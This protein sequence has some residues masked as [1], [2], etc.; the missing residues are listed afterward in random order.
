MKIIK[1][2]FFL[3]FSQYENIGLYFPVGVFLIALCAVMCISVFFITYYKKYTQALYK[4]LIR[5]NATDESSAKT[6]SQLRLSGCRGI[7]F[8]LSRSNGQLG[9]IVKR[10]GDVKPTYEEYVEKTK[11]RGYKP[12]KI[13]FDEAL[14][15]IAPD[16][17]DVAK[18]LIES[19]EPAWWK[20]IL[21]S[22]VLIGILIL[23]VFTLPDLLSLI[24]KSI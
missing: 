10:V 18:K 19:S 17:K 8:S 5:H 24:N 1:E 14:F 4:Q 21:I 9:Y 11:K 22:T 20:A 12:E 15:Y 23:L 2:F 6:L 16:K 3:N 7:R 13:N